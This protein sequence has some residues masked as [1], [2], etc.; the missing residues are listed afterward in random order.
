MQKALILVVVAMALVA[1]GKPKSSDAAAT[2]DAASAEA[3]TAGGSG[4]SVLNPERK[5]IDENAAHPELLPTQKIGGSE[6]RSPFEGNR[7]IG[8]NAIVR[9]SLDTIREFDK[10]VPAIRAAA[11]TASRTGAAPDRDAAE[12]GLKTIDAFYERALSARDDMAVAEKDL[13][14]SG[15][16]YDDAIFYGMVKFTQDV[17]LEI[18]E[19]KAALAA[20]LGG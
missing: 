16:Y 6:G 12:A 18:R 14:A 15:E 20:K 8:L 13:V 1:C 9:R 7:V 2:S 3:A 17:E 10:A 11:E 4:A 5:A 19:E